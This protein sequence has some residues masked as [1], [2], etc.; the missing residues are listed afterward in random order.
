MGKDDKEISLER[1]L[2]LDHFGNEL[3]SS[4]APVRLIEAI[5]CI[6]RSMDQCCY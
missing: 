5:A 2:G 4:K 6:L 3:D 1:C